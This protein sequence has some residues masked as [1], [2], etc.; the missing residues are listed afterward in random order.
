MWGNTRAEIAQIRWWFERGVS[1]DW[2]KIQ[3][4][5]GAG[6]SKTTSLGWACTVRHAAHLRH[7]LIPSGSRCTTARRHHKFQMPKAK[8]YAPR[9]MFYGVIVGE[10]PWCNSS[11][12]GSP[13][14]FPLALCPAATRDGWGGEL[15]RP[16]ASEADPTK[17]EPGQKPARA[18][19]SPS[20]SACSGIWSHLG[21]TRWLSAPVGLSRSSD[22]ARQKSKAVTPGEAGVTWPIHRV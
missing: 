4:H 1:C 14:F 6:A 21:P 3:M 8:K 7:G 9:E 5:G 18:S 22:T 10:R 12:P 15:L 20:Q 17:R 13:S 2:I 16:P 11:Y 19:R